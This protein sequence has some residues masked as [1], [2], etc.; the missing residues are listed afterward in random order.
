ML[1]YVGLLWNETDERA[2]VTAQ[3][4][5][6]KLRAQ[7]VC[8]ESSLEEGG[9][10]VLSADT[11]TVRL[12]IGQ[13]N[14]SGI[15]LGHLFTRVDGSLPPAVRLLESSGRELA[16]SYWGN[17]VALWRDTDRGTHWAMRGPASALPCLRVTHCGVDLYFSWAETCASLEEIPFSINWRY[18]GRSLIGPVTSKQTG[19]NE[20]TELLPGFCEETHGA[21]R[22]QR[23]CWDP[24]A[25]AKNQPIAHFDSAA[26]TL[27]AVT[28]SCI[29]AWAA[30]TP[31]ILHALSGGLDSSIVLG[32]LQD[33]PT[34]PQITAFTYFADGADS[35]ERVFAR[36]AVRRAGC[37]HIE[38]RRDD[39]E[40]DLRSGF[41]KVR[42]ERNAG[43]RI[44]AVDRIEPECAAAVGAH[45]IYKGYGGDEL[46]CR[47]HTHYYVADALRCGDLRAGLGGLLLH[48]AVTEG[49]SIWK[50]LASAIGNAFLPHRWNTTRVFSLDQED[51]G[52]VR[53]EVIRELQADR[54]Y[55]LPFADSTHACPPGKLWQISLITGWRP[56]YTPSMRVHDPPVI[57]PLLS[58]PII[59]TCLR[60]PTYLQMKGRQERAV[61]R[62]AFAEEVPREILER[63]WK[64]GAEQLAWRLFRRN[65]PLIREIL[66]D[67]QLVRHHI[68]DRPRLEAALVVS[69][70]SGLKAT[71]PVFELLG[72][73]FWLH[74]WS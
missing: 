11:P 50:V 41:S 38:W 19:I 15:V 26:S 34:Q 33:A 6:S 68:V 51:Q 52:L 54:A 1:R 36:C 48:S 44:P 2:N 7:D 74:A 10:V 70:A 60:I 39:A 37:E 22:I 30:R 61:A 32:C 45:A 35:D 53:A 17:Y 3:R 49:E 24:V 55:D 73:E 4:L 69:P 62:A 21:E 42:L 64:G 46:F 67:G 18:V 57:A 9:F 72:T 28:K 31:Q 66:L 27:H 13:S 56:Y 23:C 25:M 5:I 71:V 14:R 65:L 47:H 43:L 8:W 59:E 40:V 16:Q 29:H 20:I 63:R 12:S 58:Q